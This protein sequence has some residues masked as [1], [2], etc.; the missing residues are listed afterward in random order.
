MPK[1]LD[2]LSAKGRETRTRIIS[3]AQK[4]FERD[5][6]VSSQVSDIVKDANAA[7]GTF[8]TYFD[9]K[10]AAFAAVIEAQERE[11]AGAAN[12]S[13]APHATVREAVES[14]NRAYIE[15]YARHTRLLAAWLEAAA[16]NKVLSEKLEALTE[17]NIE[18][19]EKSLARLKRQGKV[20]ADIQ[21]YYA[22][23]ALNAMVMHS[24]IRLFRD[25]ADD[26]DVDAA[27]DTVTNI[28]CRGIGLAEE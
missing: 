18:R 3:S 20:A 13:S 14:S 11:I 22:A 6:F 5:G 27:V 15:G 23:R 17:A 26:V 19:T 7:Y 2:E 16:V 12:V 9:S 1:T 28:W 25:A 10:E 21:P 8:Y 4:I 24:S